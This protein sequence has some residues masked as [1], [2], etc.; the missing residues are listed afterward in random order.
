MPLIPQLPQAAADLALLDTLILQTAEAANHLAATMS[1]CNSAFWS[2]PDDRLVAV[3]NANVSRTAAVFASNSSLGAAVNDALDAI[4][5]NALT[6]RAPVSPG[7]ELRVDDR[8]AFVVV[9]LPVQPE[10]AP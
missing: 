5:S 10:V 8:G 3:L 2:L 1:R 6:A 4:D 9:P 7:R